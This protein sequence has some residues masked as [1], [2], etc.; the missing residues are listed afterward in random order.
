M[1]AFIVFASVLGFGF[2]GIVWL[3]IAFSSVLPFLALVPFIYLVI[4]FYTGR[5]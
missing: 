2:G 5:F 3:S 4:T 1:I